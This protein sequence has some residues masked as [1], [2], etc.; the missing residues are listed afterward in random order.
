[1][2]FF[3]SRKAFGDDSVLLKHEIAYC[4]GQMQDP[5]AVPVLKGLLEDV[6]EHP[7]VRHEAGEALGAIATE[8][9]LEIVERFI[10]DSAIEVR[11]TCEIAADRIKWILAE[12]KNNPEA[13]KIS[14]IF[15][16][17]DPA[18][19]LEEQDHVALGDI[20]A[21][22]SQPLFHRYRALFT[23]RDMNNDKG[24]EGLLRGCK[25]QSALLRHEI[26]YVLGQLSNPISFDGLKELVENSTEHPMVRHEAAEAIGALP[27]LHVE[28]FLGKFL[29]DPE[30][31][32]NESCKVALD[33]S[34]Y[35]QSDSLEYADGVDTN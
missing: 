3:F 28:E 11:E 1:M 4:L 24:V 9:C 16:T 27:V 20:L 6:N 7:V 25:S 23:L 26:A 30:R 5:A 14:D 19:A 32:V 8:E 12:K 29:N 18:P 17:V 33:I 15:H 13:G 21:D 10:N 31:I 2:L 34:D 35:Y 22:E